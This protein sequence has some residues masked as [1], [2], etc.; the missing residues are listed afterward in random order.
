MW[1]VFFIIGVKL[2]IFN[3]W[4]YY[5]WFGCYNLFCLFYFNFIICS[6][7]IKWNFLIC[8]G[9]CYIVLCSDLCEW[10]GD[11]MFN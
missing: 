11:M 3:K 2:W 4:I 10:I 7:L 5:V 6:D 1:L 8:Y 9:Y